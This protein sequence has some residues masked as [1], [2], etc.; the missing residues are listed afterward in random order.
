MKKKFK[1]SK[2]SLRKFIICL[3]RNIEYISKDEEVKNKLETCQEKLK[4]ISDLEK[5][6][7]N[8]YN[9]FG[10]CEKPAELWQEKFVYQYNFFG[11]M[12][13]IIDKALDKFPSETTK[14]VLESILLTPPDNE[15]KY[16]K[17]LFMLR[18]EIVEN[19][20]ET[21][22]WPEKEHMVKTFE[23]YPSH[24]KF[25]ELYQKY[26]NQETTMG[27]ELQ[28]I[29]AYNYGYIN[30]TII[31]LENMM[32]VYRKLYSDLNERKKQNRKDVLETKIY[33]LEK[34]K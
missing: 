21:K 25:S 12:L 30:G 1:L 4:E 6:I 2:D 7:K 5:I 13:G 8:D 9:R 28:L 10:E 17:K 20:K 33:L 15:R 31:D 29:N 18:R 16:I 14:F 23:T 26:I 34:R 11:T 22:V 27:L 3:G 19:F 32:G 24:S